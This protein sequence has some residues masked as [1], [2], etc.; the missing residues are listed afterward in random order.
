[1]PIKYP[2]ESVKVFLYGQPKTGKSTFASK[3][4]GGLFL[5]TEA[6]LSFL[7]SKNRPIQSWADFKKFLNL[8][9]KSPEKFEAVN[10]FIVDTVDR[11]YIL[12]YTEVLDG[13]NIKAPRKN[14]FGDDWKAIRMEW[15]S[16]IN[17]LTMLNKGVL[18]IGHA[19]EIEVPVE[20]SLVADTTVPGYIS[21]MP[22]AGKEIVWKLCDFSWCAD[23][24][25]VTTKDKD[26]KKIKT[27]K[28]Y[29]YCLPTERYPECG[30]RVPCIPKRI[31]FNYP[32][33]QAAFDTALRQHFGDSAK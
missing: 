9:E 25:T 29:V 6:G 30:G 20:D 1:M 4:K 19:K 15:E 8:A 21:S 32:D 2:I 18:L 24:V 12:C 27:T 5:S 17:R 10:I 31:P 22:N 7:K 33:I 11:L 23:Q 3:L 28:P 14:N 13:L 26:G 16:A